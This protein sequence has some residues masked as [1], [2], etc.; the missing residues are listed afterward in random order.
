MLLRSISAL[1][2]AA[3][4]CGAGWA[5]EVEEIDPQP[6]SGRIGWVYDYEEG[7]RLARESGKPLWV[8]FRCER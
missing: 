3:V 2:L 6:V 8:V 5:A 1:G 4:V 7:K